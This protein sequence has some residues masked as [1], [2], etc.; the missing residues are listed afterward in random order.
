MTGLVP[1]DD[2]NRLQRRMNKLM[3]D[4]GLADF[5]AR[6]LPEIR[7]FQERMNQVMEE[8]M[9]EAP[10][11]TKEIMAPLADI[12]ETDEEILAAYKKAWD[13]VVAEQ[14]AKDEFFKKVWDDFS[15]FRANYQIWKEMG[16]LPRKSGGAQ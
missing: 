9:K 6:H 8:F 2:I 12:K 16:L 10:V 11:S 14:S 5:E 3:E 15:A 13:Q 7:R 1:I 4:M